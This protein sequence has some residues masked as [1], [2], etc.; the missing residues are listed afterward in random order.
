MPFSSFSFHF[1]NFGT[2]SFLK[3]VSTS[4]DC[5]SQKNVLYFENFELI[6]P[7]ECV[8][9]DEEQARSRFFGPPANLRASF[10]PPTSKTR[11]IWR[12]INSQN[13]SLSLSFF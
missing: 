3:L 11:K 5:E 4:V 2:F 1:L 10:Y 12:T 7:G 9:T 8:I 6:F 13:L